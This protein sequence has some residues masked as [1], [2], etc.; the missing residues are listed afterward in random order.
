VVAALARRGDEVLLTRRRADQPHGGQWE[1]P[2]GKMEPGES[3]SEALVRE[4]REELGVEVEVDRVYD[5]IFHRY[6]RFDVLMMLY[7]CRIVS[8]EPR[9]VEV[10]EVAW[11]GRQALGRY[12]ILPADLPLVARLQAEPGG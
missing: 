10:A 1:F 12:D 6:P 7:E 11:V 3:P 5:V 4:L 9:A 2:G 8:G